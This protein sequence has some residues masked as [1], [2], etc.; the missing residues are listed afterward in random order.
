MNSSQTRV[1]PCKKGVEVAPFEDFLLPVLH[2]TVYT[3][4]CLQ[5]PALPGEVPNVQAAFHRTSSYVLSFSPFPYC[6]CHFGGLQMLLNLLSS[7]SIFRT[8]MD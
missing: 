6:F 2:A 5:K 7:V 4:K 3:R 1:N 8:S